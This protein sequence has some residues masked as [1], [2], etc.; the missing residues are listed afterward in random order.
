[1]ATTIDSKSLENAV[2]SKCH[3]LPCT[4]EYNGNANI[5]NFFSPTILDDAGDGK[6]GNL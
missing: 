6:G 4:I 3:F 5:S 2:E 1:M